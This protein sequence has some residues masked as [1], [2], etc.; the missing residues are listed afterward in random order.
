MIQQ[1]GR[2]ELLRQK[3]LRKRLGRTE[4]LKYPKTR[5]QLGWGLEIWVAIIL[6]KPPTNET[7]ILINPEGYISFSMGWLTL[8]Y[9]AAQYGQFE[10]TNS[11]SMINLKIL[12]KKS[13]N[14]KICPH[15]L[16]TH[17]KFTGAPMQRYAV[18]FL[19]QRCTLQM[20]L[21]IPPIAFHCYQLRT[22]STNKH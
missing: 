22:C 14:M 21:N 12:L 3:K 13:L 20:W 10:I 9:T 17:I 15:K 18:K 19:Q 6:F 8:L 4:F 7:R 11:L 5:H 1:T 2:Y 16:V